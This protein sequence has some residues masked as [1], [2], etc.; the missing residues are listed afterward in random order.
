MN[1]PHDQ[2]PGAPPPPDPPNPPKKN[3]ENGPWPPDSTLRQ[4]G[5]ARAPPVF[6]LRRERPGDSLYYLQLSRAPR[7]QR[8]QLLATENIPGVK[9]VKT[10][11]PHAMAPIFSHPAKYQMRTAGACTPY[12]HSARACSQARSTSSAAIRTFCLKARSSRSRAA[13]S[14]G[15]AG[16]RQNDAA[17]CILAAGVECGAIFKE[18]S[19]TSSGP[20]RAR[21]ACMEATRVLR[22]SKR[23][24]P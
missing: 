12:N 21:N 11:R 3:I 20:V 17:A 14:S 22:L 7:K 4:V 18:L 1:G 13:R 2:L 24:E 23:R 8:R 6:R 15:A 10:E 9:R 16:V 5:H 19:A